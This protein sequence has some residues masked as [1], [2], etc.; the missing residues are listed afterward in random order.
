MKEAGID[1]YGNGTQAMGDLLTGEESFDHV[2][3]VCDEANAERCLVLPGSGYRHHW[4][5]PVQGSEEERLPGTRRIRD[6]ISSSHT[7]MVLDAL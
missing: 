4:G 2:I 7:G 5:F 1:I 3:T 6:Q